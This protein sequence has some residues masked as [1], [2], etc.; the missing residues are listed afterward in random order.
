MGLTLDLS[1]VISTTLEGI[2]YGFSVF[3]FGV[4]MYIL[5]V[6]AR[7]LDSGVN[8]KMVAMSCLLLVCS[9]AHMIIDI[10]RTCR[11]FVSERDTFPGGPVAFFAQPSESTFVAKNAVYTVQTVLGDGI[12]IYRCYVV[13]QSWLIIAFPLLLL[14]WIAVAGILCVHSAAVVPHGA[15]TVF[16][17]DVGRWITAFYSS[18]LATNLIVTILLGYKIWTTN[19]RVAKLR[20][21]SL[22]PVVRVIADAG[23]LY[24]V[25]LTAALACFVQKSN[26]QYLVL[27]M[28]TPIISITFYMV[29]IRVGLADSHRSTDPG[30]SSYAH[31][32]TMGQGIGSRGGAADTRGQ[33][34]AMNRLPVKVHVTKVYETDG[35]TTFDNDTGS[36]TDRKGTSVLDVSH[37]V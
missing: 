21:G 28:V 32:H 15:G 36:D 13:W 9:T 33:A 23:I 26:G 8:L 11:G 14:V 25:I 35:S 6:N 19:R 1:A 29:I 16:L 4:T 5:K 18:T 7:R 24:S 27:D 17:T 30:S 12:L 22:L 31:Q 20:Q 3:M 10:V 37:A 2:L 34:V